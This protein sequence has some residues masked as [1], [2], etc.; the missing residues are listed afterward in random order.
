[1]LRNILLTL[2]AGMVVALGAFA[3]S[4]G[5]AAR[6]D[7]G[8]TV[9]KQSFDD[10]T[11]SYEAKVI[12]QL[13][14]SKK[15]KAQYDALHVKLDAETKKMMAMKSGHVKKG[16]EIN[17]MLHAGLKKIFTK[18]QYA[19]YMKLWGRGADG[20]AVATD[21]LTFK[22]QGA[23]GRGTPMPFGADTEKKILASLGLTEGQEKQIEQLYV[24]VDLKTKEM[25][26]LIEAGDT[27]AAGHK[28]S[29]INKFLKDGMKRI[30]TP[31]QYASYKKQWDAI[32]APYLKRDGKAYSPARLMAPG[33]NGNG[34]NTKVAGKAGG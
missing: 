13:G 34:G 26:T 5:G 3:I 31:A 6:T 29:E 12:G 20:D 10:G 9:K 18:A 17:K 19:K 4:Q 15:Q 1:M 16:M 11:A 23:M 25:K 8:S 27:M 22:S 21:T 7:S 28:S 30:M 24:E 32:M 2:S 14:L 33:R